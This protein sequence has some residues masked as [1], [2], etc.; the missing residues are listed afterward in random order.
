M[1]LSKRTIFIQTQHDR[2]RSQQKMKIEEKNNRRHPVSPE[3]EIGVGSFRARVYLFRRDY[4]VPISQEL[5]SYKLHY[6][7]GHN[8]R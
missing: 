8:K 7:T 4:R 3:E 2:A 1:P 5:F 6:R